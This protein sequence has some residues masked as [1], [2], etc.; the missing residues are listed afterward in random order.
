MPDSD[1]CACECDESLV[2]AASIPRTGA[3]TLIAPVILAFAF[4]RIPAWRD[5]WLPSLATIPVTLVAGIAFSLIGDG[6]ATR[7]AT[8]IVV[9]WMA[10]VSIRLLQK[11]DVEQPAGAAPAG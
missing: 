9:G 4:R 8:V 3:A 1:L 11:S 5:S 6:A 7:V 2:H 10:F